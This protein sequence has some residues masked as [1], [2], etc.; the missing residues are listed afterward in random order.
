MYIYNLCSYNSNIIVWLN[1]YFVA[2]TT[3]FSEPGYYYLK[4]GYGAGHLDNGGSYITLSNPDTKDF[5]I[6]IETMVCGEE[7]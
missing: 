3:Q 5:T 4:H 7:L 2:H 1:T 6:V